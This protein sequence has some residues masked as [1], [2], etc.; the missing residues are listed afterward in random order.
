MPNDFETH[1]LQ[2]LL[3]L[4]QEMVQP[5]IPGFLNTMNM[6]PGVSG[7]DEQLAAMTGLAPDIYASLT[8]L[9]LPPEIEGGGVTPPQVQN[10]GLVR[11]QQM[12]RPAAGMPRMQGSSRPNM[13]DERARM[14]RR[15]Q[16]A[17][18]MREQQ[19]RLA[20]KKGKR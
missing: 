8:A 1:A 18:A 4:N 15:S 2:K 19:E 6:L 13:D 20:K 9:L 12:P 5:M 10:T 16:R 7:P 11:P 17:Q 3:G 14:Q